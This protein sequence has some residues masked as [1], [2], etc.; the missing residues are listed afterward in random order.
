MSRSTTFIALAAVCLAVL[1]A[2]L[3]A[4]IITSPPADDHMNN[5]TKTL[6]GT[7]ITYH[8]FAG[9][10]MNFTIGPNDIQSVERADHDGQPAWK[11]RVGQGMQWDLIMDRSGRQI[12]DIK[13]LFV[14]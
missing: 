6:V 13:Q 7:N 11:V 2:I 4:A 14:T 3:T 1:A 8:N 9:K 10:P 5:I 12:L